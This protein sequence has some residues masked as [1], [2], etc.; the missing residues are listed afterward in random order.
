MRGRCALYA[1]A[2]LC[3]I[4]V[5]GC[6]PLAGAGA[7][8]GPGAGAGAGA[9]AGGGAGAGV[10]SRSTPA[11]STVARADRTH[12]VPTPAGR[13][14]ASP[15][16][17]SPEQAVRAFATVYVNWTAATVSGRLRTLARRSIGQARA[18]LELQSREV[19]ADRELHRGRIANSGT[20]EAVGRLAG[21]PRRYAV[22]TRERTS[23]AN[24]AAYRGL[25][26]EWHVSVATVTRVGRR[27]VLS[28][29]QPES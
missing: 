7:G 8:A 3:G 22:V 21:S 29:W 5:S 15:G 28:G 24:D 2:V 20:V 1:V 13:E 23:A 12:E 17:A 25:A 27:W 19:A 6:A 26:P 16:W 9:G 18:T 10:A 11:A 4:A 14:R